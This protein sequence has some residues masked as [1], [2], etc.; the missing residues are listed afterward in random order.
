[1]SLKQ[2]AS[3][4]SEVDERLAALITNSNAVRAISAAVEGTLGPK[5]LDTMLVDRFGEVVITNDGV[6]ILSMM[7]ASHPAAKMVINIAKSQ[8][9]EI[10]DGTTTAT[11]MAGALVSAGV[12]QVARGVPVAR[13]IEGLR[14]GLRRAQGEIE[15][16]A[17]AVTG[18]DDPAIR[19]VALVAGREH[20]DIADLVVSAAKL[21]GQE[22]LEDTAFKL[23][24]AVLAEEGAENG[25]FMG[26]IIGKERMNKQMPKDLQQVKVLVIDDAL[27]PEEIEEESLGT[28]SGFARYLE[29]QN[30]FRTN[31]QKIIDLGV[32]LVL[33]DRGVNDL[34]EEMLTDAGIMVLQRVPNKE[35]SKA[36]E[37]CGARMVK[38]TGLK[39]KEPD[40]A[41]YLGYAQRV[42]S[43]EKLE[44]VWILEGSGKPMATVLVGAATSEVVGE[45]QRIAKDAAAA[46]QAAVKGGVVPGGGSLE[47]AVARE[48]EKLREET[49]GMAGFGVDCVVEALKRPM[50]QIVS[51][52]GF[53]PLE[54]MGDVY[55][56]QI[57]QGKASIALDCDSGE[58]ADMLELGV[59]DPALVKIYALKAA[60]EIAEAILRIDTIIKMRDGKSGDDGDVNSD[61]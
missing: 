34:A 8:Q 28:E 48:V 50:A 5:G 29:L 38:R 41:K 52:A 24:D 23:A 36:A 55:V 15:K 9:E 6:T 56:A 31:L 42:K 11:V 60:G 25:V 26:V 14:A 20:E 43:D 13:V 40:L 16:Q 46:V 37:H 35:L 2:H 59:V 10:G 21:I 30:E 7:E 32:G 19:Q 4:G 49:R 61:V 22:K 27:E 44:Q 53:N 51:N 47:L 39:K 17:R 3:Q 45:R 57:E 58:V 12:D 54:K 1:M 33:V 18:L